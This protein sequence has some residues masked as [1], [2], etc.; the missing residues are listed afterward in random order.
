MLIISLI[1]ISEKQLNCGIKAWLSRKSTIG[2]QIVRSNIT[3]YRFENKPTSYGN[4]KTGVSRPIRATYENNT[5]PRIFTSV[6]FVNMIFSRTGKKIVLS[7]RGTPCQKTDGEKVYF[8]YR[9]H[10]NQKPSSRRNRIDR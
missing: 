5:E 7:P 1:T 2:H 6:S 9:Y 10:Q 4:I 8:C 3:S